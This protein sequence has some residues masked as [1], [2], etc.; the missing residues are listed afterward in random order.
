M[1]LIRLLF[2]LLLSVAGAQ[3]LAQAG[4]AASTPEA[5]EAVEPPDVAAVTRQLVE[6]LQDPAARDA[7][8]AQLRGAAAAGG[9]A[10]A[11]APEPAPEAAPTIA[12]AIADQTLGVA[13]AVSGY[14]AGGV[15]ALHDWDGMVEAVRSVDWRGMLDDTL[16]I[17]LVAVVSVATYLVLGRLVRAVGAAMARRAP[18]RGLAR[19][20]LI[21]LPVAIAELAAL[22]V[23][24]AAGY[25]LALWLG[26]GTMDFRQS[27]FL[28]AFLAVEAAKLV[29]RLPLEPEQPELRLLPLGDTA[30]REWYLTPARVLTLLGYGVLLFVPLVTRL[31]SPAFGKG[32]A[33]GVILIAALLAVRLILRNRL[34]VRAA[35]R[36][37]AAR[38]GTGLLGG[39]LGLL[40]EFW[41]LLAILYVLGLLVV[42]TTRP[43]D[44]LSF[45]LVATAKSVAVVV[46]G[47]LGIALLTRTIVG[48]VHFSDGVRTRLPMLEGRV[49]ALVPNFLNLFRI[50]VFVVGLGLVAEA[51]SVFDFG[52]WLAG[53][54]GQRVVRSLISASMILL[55][56][57]VIWLAVSSWIEYK[58]NPTDGR[59]VTARASTLLSLL[60]NAFTILIVVMGAMLA[61]SAIGV[62]IAPLLAGAG[63]VGL[64]VG[65]GAQKLVQDIITGAFIQFENVMNTGD[66]VT[67][68]GI[69]GTVEKLTIRS[70]GL[71][72]LE[73][74]YHV[75]PFSSVDTVSNLMRDFAYHVAEMGVAYR[76][77]VGE[78]KATMQE[79][80]ERLQET[81]FGVDILGP[82]DM[83]GIVGFAD[84]AVL[85]RARIRTR[86]GRQF[87]L[88]R[89]YNELLKEAF[90]A[91]GIEMPFPHLTI[92]MGEDKSGDA[93]AL[94]IR[95][96]TRRAPARAL[97]PA[98]DG[99]DKS[100]G[101]AKALELEEAPEVGASLPDADGR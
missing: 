53:E 32:V 38:S 72:T 62:N 58:L 82:L 100:T 12:G 23:A 57:G 51:W 54:T 40:A 1:A 88:G 92:Y 24:W 67:A 86:P 64:A 42:W 10:P 50:L 94:N 70:V 84:S 69:T 36:A 8:L 9:E 91:A 39:A 49:N 47:G 20:A 56:T 83:Q 90:D 60:R 68:G 29:L 35:L 71:R 14:V 5:A 15:E 79:A 74:A 3:A 34:A 55:V 78:V 81:D 80:F 16:A 89:A 65:F 6:V 25:G 77:D 41:H 85:V 33:V 37:R 66:V 19:R 99:R 22:L 21:L 98:P 43:G 30:A 18:G 48:G 4:P 45:M 87:A 76:E 96:A 46:L 28:N 93:P 101:P 75:V 7:F 31:V 61:L 73:G 52:G 27:L 97:E 11:A 44:L 59:A 2:I 17:G 13:E 95:R 63:V 26:E